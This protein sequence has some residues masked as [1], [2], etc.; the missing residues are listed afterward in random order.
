MFV[1]NR[2]SSGTGLIKLR[3][4]PICGAQLESHGASLRLA[5]DL[6]AREQVDKAMRIAADRTDNEGKVAERL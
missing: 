5:P 6:V 3:T 1:G 4:Y 2:R